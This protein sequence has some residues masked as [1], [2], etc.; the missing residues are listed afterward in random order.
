MLYVTDA[1]IL[2][3]AKFTPF[4]FLLFVTFKLFPNFIY[5]AFKTMTQK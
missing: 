4:P 1:Y 5:E 3:S 2:E